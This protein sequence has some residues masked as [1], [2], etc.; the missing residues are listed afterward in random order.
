M[1]RQDQLQR[2]VDELSLMQVEVQLLTIALP[3]A[4]RLTGCTKSDYF[5]NTL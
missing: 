3:G 4:S 5:R 2:A 1:A